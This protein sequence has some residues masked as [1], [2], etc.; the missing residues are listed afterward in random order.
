[1]AD[2][3]KQEKPA[4]DA[5]PAE[6]APAKK[7]LPIK[8][9]GVVAVIMVL[10]AAALYFV[11][12]ALK[13]PAASHAKVDA[14]DLKE[15][16]SEQTAEIRVLEEKDERFQNLS[17]GRVWVWSVSVYVQVKNK[18]TERVERVLE[19]RRAEIREGISQIVGRAQ[20]AQ[21]K[22]PERQ[23]L[24]RQVSAFLDKIIGQDPD[25]KP[26][27]ERLL[28]PTCSGYLAD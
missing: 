14:K 7:G 24:N 20:I 8:T 17:A 2:K 4:A 5:A 25:G 21:L 18:N 15:D 16:D 6:A 11:I 10:E 19:M 23:S 28:I 13:G 1:M 3:P 12:S 9:I 27:V 26:L 22:E